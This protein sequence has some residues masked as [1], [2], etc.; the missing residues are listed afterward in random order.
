MEQNACNS[1][2]FYYSFLFFAFSVKITQ[3]KIDNNP[4]AKGFRDTGNGRREKRYLLERVRISGR[5]WMALYVMSVC[6][7]QEQTAKRLVVAREPQQS[8]A[9]LRWLWRLVWTAQHKWI[10]LFTSGTGEQPA[11]VHTDLSR[12]VNLLWVC[13]NPNNVTK[14]WS[15]LKLDT[16]KVHVYFKN[17]GNLWMTWDCERI[18]VLGKMSI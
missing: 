8:G 2:L 11:D 17:S 3:L 6:A 14:R 5:T 13:M 15:N 4:F 1:I 10:F 12:W 7:P 16:G 9:G 18:T